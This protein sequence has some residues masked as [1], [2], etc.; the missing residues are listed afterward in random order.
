LTK[1]CHTTR[2]KSYTENAEEDIATKEVKIPG[3][4][5]YIKIEMI[6]CFRQLNIFHQQM[7]NRSAR[8]PNRLS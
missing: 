7:R 1:D 8:I 2:G 5:I 6:C 3:A 4:L